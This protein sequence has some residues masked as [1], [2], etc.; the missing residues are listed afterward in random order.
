M[1]TSILRHAT[2]FIPNTRT[3]RHIAIAIALMV[4]PMAS[5]WAG[6]AA[7]I[8]VT[9]NTSIYPRQTTALTITLSNSS[10]VYEI[11][12]VALNNLLRPLHARFL[13]LATLAR[14]N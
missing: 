3:A 14:P 11:T 6:L 12:N 4:F 7:S 5:A 1:I 13:T 10:T 2:H 8:G 9:G